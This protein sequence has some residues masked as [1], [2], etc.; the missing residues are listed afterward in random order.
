MRSLGAL[1]IAGAFA[2]SLART[3][4]AEPI[5]DARFWTPEQ[6]PPRGYQVER[7]VHFADVG[8]GFGVFAAAY[9]PS[10]FVATVGSSDPGKVCDANGCR[11]PYWP[12]FIPVVGPFISFATVG[13]MSSRAM[14]WYIGLATFDALTQGAGLALAV[15]GLVP[16]LTLVKSSQWS[17]SLLPM[18]NGLSLSGT[19]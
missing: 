16:R 11:N 19:F 12:F 7:R 9:I 18:R 10:L 13:P 15:F 2:S 4:S 1:L 14:D 3:S 5:D 17:A 6:P 8:L